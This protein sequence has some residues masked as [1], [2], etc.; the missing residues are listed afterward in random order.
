[1]IVTHNLIKLSMHVSFMEFY[2]QVHTF[3]VISILFELWFYGLVNQLGSCWEW[4]FSLLTLFLGKS[5]KQ[6]ITSTCAHT[7]AHQWQLPFLN[8]RKGGEWL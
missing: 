1:M 7:F 5:S 8:K 4:S 2:S 3:K 6:L